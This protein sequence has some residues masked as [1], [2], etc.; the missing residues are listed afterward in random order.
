M[1]S[2]TCGF[3]W[4]VQAPDGALCLGRNSLALSKLMFEF[5][6][7]QR[8]KVIS[9]L[10]VGS[11]VDVRLIF[12]FLQPLNLILSFPTFV[13]SSASILRRKGPRPQWLWTVAVTFARRIV[14]SLGKFM[15]EPSGCNT[16]STLWMLRNVAS[17]PSLLRPVAVSSHT[18]K[19]R[20][21]CLQLEKPFSTEQSF[22]VLLWE[23]K[24]T[25]T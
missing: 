12:I 7:D 2:K 17:L 5:L 13:V 11:S 24:H 16:G 23:Q 19:G 18:G 8:V 9:Y 25:L 14:T 21:C 1:P 10:I 6:R 20:P 3:V 22:W 4:L 15:E